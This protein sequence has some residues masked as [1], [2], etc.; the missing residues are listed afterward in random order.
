MATLVLAALILAP[1]ERPIALE[2]I[3]TLAH[4]P[5]REASGIVRSRQFPGVFWVHN[6]SGNPPAL[7]AVKRDGTLIREY[8]VNV[9][10]VDW[11][12]IATDDQGHLYIG[13]IGNNDGRLPL[14]AIYQVDE[15][16]PNKEGDTLLRLKK[17]SYYRFPL[18]AAFNAE[19][20][21]IEG[22][23]AL[24]IAKTLDGR[25]AEV[26]AIPL[27]PPAPLLNPALPE[28]VTTLPGFTK[29]VTGAALSSDGAMLA[30]CSV[31]SLGVYEKAKRGR[32][33]ALS[34]HRFRSEDQIEAVTWDGRDILLAGESRAMFRV[35][36]STWQQPGER[37]D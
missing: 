18:K 36:E 1:P 35:P 27:E 31:E 22:D 37:H 2:R 33:M 21:L 11:E 25:D 13:E 16:D 10:N 7:F 28:K 6:D 24:I 3:G 8:R 14:R 17:A 15:P 34:L 32:W 5:I 20:L 29:P 19:A 30:V 23:R 12:D 9:A 26:F 4:E